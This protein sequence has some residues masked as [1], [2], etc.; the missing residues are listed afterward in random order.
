[1]NKHL[2]SLSSLVAA[3]VLLSAAAAYASPDANPLPQNCTSACISSYGEVLG[4]TFDGTS[5]Y[6][7]CK[8]DCVVF[9]PNREH[10]VY[11]GIKWQCVE[12]ARRWLIRNRGLTFGDVDTAADIWAIDS[13]T[14]L[15]DGSKV[16]VANQLNGSNSLPQKG[17]LLIYAKEYLGTGHAAVVLD[18]DSAKGL[19][20][21]GEENY[22]NRKWPAN[23]ARSIE[24][25][26][27]NGR[28]W[29]LDAYLLGWKHFP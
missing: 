21:V 10:G 15:V 14:R 5:A 9:D 12:F 28:Y 23:Y 29:L 27:R 7:N 6:S 25:I 8:A 1:V 22:E 13:F 26:A 20:R 24:F 3:L 19:I 18:V 4:A 16:P 2:T 17:D 11:S